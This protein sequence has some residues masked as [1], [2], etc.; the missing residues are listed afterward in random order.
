MQK[1]ILCTK[2]HVQ[3]KKDNLGELL[4]P[5]C[6]ARVCPKA[7]VFDGKI[8][9][10]CGWEDPNYHLWQKAQKARAQSSVPGK[11]QES[12]DSK[13]QYMCPRCY[14][15]VNVSRG[16]CPN[17]RGCGYSGPMKRR[18]VREPAA[19]ATPAPVSKLM[20]TISRSSKSVPLAPSKT[21]I[22]PPRSPILSE[23]AK[24]ERKE[25]DFSQL[26]R[27]I[28][29]VLASLLVGIVLGGLVMGGIY[30]TRLVSQSAAEPGTRPFFPPSTP[31][32][33]YTLSISVI[34]EAGGEIRIVSPSS[35][36][37]T[38]ESGSQIT[39][40]AI[41][42]DCYTFSY[43]DGAS[44][45]SE[46]INIVM[47]TDKTVVAHFRLKDTTPP[48]ISEV[49]T[50]RYSDISATITWE[51][52]EPAISQ[53]DYGTTD[54]Y[55]ETTE[56]N[57]DP[58]TNHVVRLTNLKPNTTYYIKV[59]AIDKCGNQASHT[60][61]LRTLNEIPQGYVVGSRFLDFEFPEYQDPKQRPPNDGEMVRLSQ[62]KGK[63]ILLNFWHTFCGACIGEVGLIREIYEDPNLANKNAE[64]AAVVVLTVCTDGRADRIEKLED[65]YGSDPEVG[66]FTF[67][68]LLDLEGDTE[69]SYRISTV[70]RTLFID[71][72][73]VIR[74][75]KTGR[76]NSKEEIEV[77]LKSL[78]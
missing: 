47:D 53:V 55:G 14:T 69:K 45:S 17:Q 41:P 7:H 70:P 48:A 35:S 71:S 3:V 33:T 50:T 76:F 51:T 13:P 44:D 62:F 23:M 32:E 61:N 2:C 39:L 20:D 18:D 64:K 73:G 63:K 57:Y 78:E 56:F 72:D 1:I 26:K 77:I 49:K 11:P 22:A 29:P 19:S 28:R 30:I 12:F 60:S 27:F 46:T 42:D 59:E 66:A 21:S 8:C 4:C 65:K 67:P 25:W 36:S 34:P 16:V 31:S 40:M 75:I 52:D 6:G 74:E 9:T 68:I 38:F 43:W 5:N 58:A 54:N 10:Y 37:G 15:Q 24:A